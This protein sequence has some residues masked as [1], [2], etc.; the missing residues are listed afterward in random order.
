MTTGL[1]FFEDPQ[2]QLKNTIF[3]AVKLHSPNPDPDILTS[4]DLSL[5]K[6]KPYRSIWTCI[7]SGSVNLLV[8][9][10][11]FV[12]LFNV[13]IFSMVPLVQKNCQEAVSGSSTSMALVSSVGVAHLI[14]Q[15][16]R[17][18]LCISCEMSFR[19]HREKKSWLIPLLPG[20]GC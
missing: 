17:F 12:Y 15:Y 10:G 13:Y 11:R 5:Q 18:T 2:I 6:P 4:I 3:L 8:S 9:T 14:W 20:E 16:F 1:G 19:H 7:I